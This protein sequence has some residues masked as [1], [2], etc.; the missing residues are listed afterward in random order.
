ML[1]EYFFLTQTPS[2]KMLYNRLIKILRSQDRM[3]QWNGASSGNVPLALIQDSM[4]ERKQFKAINSFKVSRSVL[5]DRPQVKQEAINNPQ[6]WQ[7]CGHIKVKLNET[8]PFDVL[9]AKTPLPTA[10]LKLEAKYTSFT[11][12]LKCHLKLIVM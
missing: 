1:T 4:C 9:S 2:F 7:F 10:E 8:F 11:F 3:Y 5:C 6:R 12:K